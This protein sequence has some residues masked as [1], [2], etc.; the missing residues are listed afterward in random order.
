[1]I[2]DAEKFR[3]EDEAKI[4]ARNTF[5]NYC[6]TLKAVIEDK[7]LKRPLGST[8]LAKPEPTVNQNKGFDTQ[9]GKKKK[10]KNDLSK[11]D[12]NAVRP[13]RFDMTKACTKGTSYA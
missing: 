10:K 12:S 5:E 9:K 3:L 7:K 8:A 13:F 11:F 6:Y 2:A 1:M 4:N